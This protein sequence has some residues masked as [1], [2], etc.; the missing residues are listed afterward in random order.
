MFIEENQYVNT[1]E[2]TQSKMQFP[3]L[4]HSGSKF[5]GLE[6][7]EMDSNGTKGISFNKPQTWRFTRK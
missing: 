2:R 3:V 1:C 6:K 4:T 7:Q 5:G